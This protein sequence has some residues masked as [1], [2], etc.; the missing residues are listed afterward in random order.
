MTDPQYS[1][2]I[3]A[4]KE[5]NREKFVK[6]LV[7]QDIV[8]FK[9]LYSEQLEISETT[10]RHHLQYL[11][12]ANIV[13]KVKQSGTKALFVSLAPKFL[14][15]ARHHFKLSPKKGYLGMIGMKNLGLQVEQALKRLQQNGWTFDSL[16]LFCTPETA[17]LLGTD[18]TWN[19]LIT[20]HSNHL[21]TILPPYDFEEAQQLMENII[22]QRV[23]QFSLLADVTGSTK[24]HTLSLYNLA[25]EYGFSRIY[26]PEEDNQIILLP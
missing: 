24:I 2:F 15:R 5:E 7:E 13:V 3:D 1:T 23:K 17:T 20:K 9:T 26:L 22:Q 4:I 21:V 10:A 6:A 8:N 16:D 11:L 19:Q 14:E 25:K 12:D 18:P